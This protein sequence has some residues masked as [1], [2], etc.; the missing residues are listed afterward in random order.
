MRSLKPAQFPPLFN[1]ST[2]ESSGATPIMQAGGGGATASGQYPHFSLPPQYPHAGASSAEEAMTALG[3]LI[4]TQDAAIRGLRDSA[5]LRSYAN[6]SLNQKQQVVAGGTHFRLSTSRP[7]NQLFQFALDDLTARDTDHRLQ[8]ANEC[9]MSFYQEAATTVRAFVDAQQQNQSSNVVHLAAESLA[10]QPPVLTTPPPAGSMARADSVA[11]LE[12]NGSTSSG[13]SHQTALGALWASPADLAQGTWMQITVLDDLVTAVRASKERQVQLRVVS[14]LILLFPESRLPVT[15]NPQL[16]TQYGGKTILAVAQAPDATAPSLSPRDVPEFALALQ[17]VGESFNVATAYHEIAEEEDG[18]EVVT[19]GPPGASCRRGNDGR[20]YLQTV[21]GLFPTLPPARGAPLGSQH[22][23]FLRPEAIVRCR[24][25]VSPAAYTAFGAR[26]SAALRNST[27]EC[28]AHLCQITALELAA[29]LSAKSAKVVDAQHLVRI[30]HQ[31]GVNVSLLGVVLSNV[32]AHA[33]A[34]RTMLWTEMVARAAKDCCRELC[35]TGDDADGGGGGSGSLDEL[36]ATHYVPAICAA[37]CAGG[38]GSTGKATSAVLPD[39]PLLG[40]AVGSATGGSRSLVGIA[41]DTGSDDDQAHLWP[42][43]LVPRIR[44][45][46]PGAATLLSSYLRG[47]P[48]NVDKTQFLARFGHLMGVTFA[49]GV[50]EQGSSAFHFPIAD[51]HPVH[52][53]SLLPEFAL[54]PWESSPPHPRTASIGGGHSGS[55]TE[56]PMSMSRTSG[57]AHHAAT[58]RAESPITPVRAAS[59]GHRRESVRIN[60]KA[61]SVGLQFQLARLEFSDDPTESKAERLLQIRQKI[62]PKA[63]PAFT[64]A[65]LLHEIGVAFLRVASYAPTPSVAQS[66]SGGTAA[67]QPPSDSATSTPSRS[68]TGSSAAHIVDADRGLLALHY[69]KAAHDAFQSSDDMEPSVTFALNLAAIG[70]AQWKTAGDLDEGLSELDSATMELNYAAAVGA[71]PAPVSQD[72]RRRLSRLSVVSLDV[73]SRRS[74]VASAGS[75]PGSFR[76][77]G[78]NQGGPNVNAFALDLFTACSLMSE[79]SGDMLAAETNRRHL[80]RMHYRLLGP[81]HLRTVLAMCALASTLVGRAVSQMTTPTLVMS[82]ADARPPLG[83]GAGQGPSGGVLPGSSSTAAGSR[84]ANIAN[85]SAMVPTAT[86]H[87]TPMSLFTEAEM[88]LLSASQIVV[89]LMQHERLVESGRA[90]PPPGPSSSSSAVEVVAPLASTS[91]VASGGGLTVVEKLL[92]AIP[93]MLSKAVSSGVSY[94]PAVPSIAPSDSGMTLCSVML[95][96]WTHLG[97]LYC[98]TQRYHEAEKFY[99]LSLRCTVAVLGYVPATPISNSPPSAPISSSV[100]AASTMA[101]HSALPAHAEIATCCSN[102][103]YAYLETKQYQKAIAC[104]EDAM[105]IR[106]ALCPSLPALRWGGAAGRPAGGLAPDAVNRSPTD[107]AA[108]VA[109][110]PSATAASSLS[111]LGD[112]IHNLASTLQRVGRSEEALS[113]AMR[114]LTV[115]EK[116]LLPSQGDELRGVGGHGDTPHTTTG[117]TAPSQA[118]AS[119]AGSHP[120]LTR[121]ATFAPR[122]AVAHAQPVAQA[123]AASAAWVSHVPAHLRPRA[124]GPWSR[125]LLSLAGSDEDLAARVSRVLERWH[126]LS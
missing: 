11:A 71:P 98:R 12:S 94:L 8:Q 125:L 2:A 111:L 32:P 61:A 47:G 100:A 54:G 65:H 18:A 75:P 96:A 77:A 80:L 20:V 37:V 97:L 116:L 91:V 113:L 110:A 101:P 5:H 112:A 45:K 60:S 66:Q 88:L 87:A 109:A 1:M 104:F 115:Y 36:P 73:Q 121:S 124:I 50:D 52:K 78:G 85:L 42:N 62:I 89:D 53:M 23:L 35:M 103:A 40:A 55:G 74:S 119:A 58:Q 102:L 106:E 79:A 99:L 15:M 13:M 38:G 90:P 6:T 123:A 51:L 33:A 93:W 81:H 9:L 24:L 59:S 30:L 95:E 48:A 64:R 27:R 3:S 29:T 108:H 43:L 68:N 21:L 70:V 63:S 26:D 16:I 67:A 31:Y 76:D 34:L 22:L 57:P 44:A 19:I 118:A 117:P 17:Y 107:D 4:V 56:S 86:S 126:G 114:A 46:F 83:G 84:V 92:P 28:A 69:L 72:P 7:F 82:S 25:P 39:S 105:H 120:P 49:K 14:Q 41:E 122:N 10:S